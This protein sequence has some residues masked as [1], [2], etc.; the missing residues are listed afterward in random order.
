MNAK[1]VSSV[2]AGCATVFL[3]ASSIWAAAP[4]QPITLTYWIWSSAQQPTLQHLADM[5][6]RSH[7]NVK[8][9]VQVVPSAD[10]WTKLQAAATGGTMPDIFVMNGSEFQEYASNGMLLPIDDYVRRSHVNLANYPKNILNMYTLN[11]VHY[12]IPRNEDTIGLWYNKALFK[13]YG[14]PFPNASWTWKTLY[15]AAKK[16]TDP[17]AGVWGFAARLTSQEGF[18]NVIYQNKGYVVSKDGKTSGYHDPRTVQALNYWYSFI[19]NKLSPSIDQMTQTDPMQLFESGKVAMIFAGDWNTSIFESIPYCNKN[20]D[21]AV[22]PKGKVRASTING[23]SNVIAKTTKYPDQ[24]WDFVRF[25]GSKKAAQVI[26][27][28]GIF[29]PSYKG[30]QTLWVKAAPQFHLQ[31]L[32][33]EVAYSVPMPWTKDTSAWQTYETQ[34]LTNAFTGQEPMDQATQELAEKMNEVL[35]SQQ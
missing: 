18:Y 8:V 27:K 5:Y 33:D 25:L 21:V 30:T 3:S 28:S 35:Q 12:G 17:K 9:N 14:V 15:N 20:V 32:I 6:H 2:M 19:K 10:Y 22:L 7:P 16:L 31:N 29:V 24:A 11:G 26:A 13:K 23:T 4:Q 34:Y 1:W